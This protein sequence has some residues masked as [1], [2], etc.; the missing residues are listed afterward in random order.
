VQATDYDVVGA[1]PDRPVQ[2]ETALVVQDPL[3]W[4]GGLN[5]GNQHHDPVEP[6]LTLQVTQELDDRLAE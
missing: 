4:P 6:V 2:H 5:L 3:P 1:L